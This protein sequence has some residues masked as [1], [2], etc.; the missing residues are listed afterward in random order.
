VLYSM[1]C[2]V[3]RSRGGEGAKYEMGSRGMLISEGLIINLQTN[4]PKTA[5]LAIITGNGIRK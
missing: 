1:A 5:S 2:R 4:F 3:R